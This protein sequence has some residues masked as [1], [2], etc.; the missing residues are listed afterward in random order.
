MIN[1]SIRWRLILLSSISILFMLGFTINEALNNREQVTNLEATRV[2]IEALQSFS[3]LSGDIYR[4]LRLPNSS[5]IR[6][7][8]YAS[9]AKQ[10]GSILQYNK[11]LEGL[12]AQWDIVDEL[13]DLDQILQELSNPS[14]ERKPFLGVWAFD[15]LQEILVELNDVDIFLA[16]DNINT[17]GKIFSD[18][19]NFVFWT[20]KE[21]WV[22][23]K[24]YLYP[25]LREDSLDH[26]LSTIHRQ[27]QYLNAF[28]RSN[29][30]STRLGQLLDVFASKEYQDSVDFR[31]RIFKR[32]FDSQEIKQY[33]A[34]LEQ[35]HIVTLQVVD[36]YTTELQGQL[37]ARIKAQKIRTTLTTVF[38]ITFATL[39]FWLTST[40]SLRLNRNLSHI[41]DGMSDQNRNTEEHKP[42][43][44]EGHDELT[45]F[46]DKVNEIM[47]A[48]QQHYQDLIEAKEDA[49]SANRAKSA[50]LANMSHEIRTPLNGIIGM[51]EILSQSQLN[52]NQQE[53][54]ADIESSS[55]T[56]LVLLNDIL[57]LSK[58]ESGNLLLSPQAADL[59]EV[60]YDS[61]S[62]I[63]SKAISKNVELDINID[64]NTPHQLLFDEHRLRQV[65]TNLLSN[66]I[67]FT[68][69]GAISTTVTYTPGSMSRGMIECH[70]ADT[71]IGIEES[72]LD[73]VFEPFT[74]E[75][76][77]ITR[78]FGGTGLGLAICR[79]LIDLMDG[80]I[81]ASSVKGEGSIFSFGFYVDIVESKPKTFDNLK[82]ALIVSNSFNYVAQLTKECER[83]G[84]QSEVVPTIDDISNPQLDCDVLLYCHTLH[85]PMDHDLASLKQ[86]YPLSKVIVC[87]HHLFKTNQ[88]TES[89][90]STH[91]VPFLGKRFSNSL[92][93]LDTGATQAVEKPTKSEDVHELN[94]RILIVEDN[95][96]NQKIAS[97]FLEKAGYEYTITSNG[98]EAVDVVTQGEQFDAILMDCMMPVMDGITATQTIRAWEKEQGIAPLPIIALTAS[99]LDEDIKDCFEAGMNAYLPKPYKSH[100]LYELFDNLGIV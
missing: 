63:L 78:Q 11:Q 82:S 71:G 85:Q 34:G 27:S 99:V 17:A 95:L 60:V 52:A 9:A 93:A 4:L 59:R 86:R 30:S 28:L 62:V 72:K 49:I 35:R 10:F 41:L 89:V 91:T 57:D 67:K 8:A 53:V 38:V 96:M 1:I 73:S 43:V 77:S 18:L 74:Q 16:D 19:N 50:F 83:F 36:S 64:A 65:L 37:A 2:K 32:Q 6:K 54:L 56:L 31:E 92:L 69:S 55:H 68:D 46:A 33:V 97:F 98:Q 100:Q 21:A 26:Y 76:G 84:I 87:Q 42:I 58:I 12:S 39:V 61:V 15:V 5:P 22:G 24:L 88:I 81:T 45:Q 75:D 13:D 7:S 66:A 80:R 48:N 51:A 25:E 23:Y 29:D 90:H 20:Q 94:R 40:T 47:S 14:N 79:Q 3:T 70:V 44:T